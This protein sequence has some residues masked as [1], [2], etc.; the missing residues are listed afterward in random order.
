[1]VTCPCISCLFGVVK[2]NECDEGHA[3]PTTV[4]KH[5]IC[6]ERKNEAAIGI[7]YVENLRSFTEIG[8]QRL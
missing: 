4:I 7:D 3:K 6:N 2:C 5:N 8:H 1:M